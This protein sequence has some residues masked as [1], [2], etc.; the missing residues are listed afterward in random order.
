MLG[1]LVKV[2][3]FVRK[4]LIFQLEI[5]DHAVESIDL[6][7]KVLLTLGR[8]LKVNFLVQRFF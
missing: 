5:F 4:G 3:N 1:V 7:L 8:L 2:E 6:D